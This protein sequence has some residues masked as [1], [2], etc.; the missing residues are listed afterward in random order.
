MNNFQWLQT[1]ALLDNPK[2]EATS[3]N[4]FLFKPPHKL[5]DKKSLL[6]LLKHYDLKSLGG[7]MMDD[8]QESLPHF[9][10]ALKSL[11]NQNEIVIVQRTDKKKILFYNSNI[12]G[13]S[14]DEEFKKLWRSVAVDA[15]DDAKIEEYLEKQ[16]KFNNI[17]NTRF[18]IICLNNKLN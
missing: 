16:G 13:D 3:D 14:V 1:E 5:K 4:K 10:K 15:M 11:M 17:I 6:K 7:I 8:V 9:E 2:I 18:L 12:T